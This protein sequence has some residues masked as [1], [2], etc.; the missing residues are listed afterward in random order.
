LLLA[1]VVCPKLCFGIDNGVGLTPPMGWRSWN[2]MHGD[3]SDAR[4][5]ATVD[6]ITSRHR[7]VG[8]VG[9]SLADLGFDRVGIDDGWQ[10]CNRGKNLSGGTFHADDGTPLVN[11]TLFPNLASL[12]AFAKSRGVKMGWYINNCIC[13][14]S[15]G[16]IGGETGKNGAWVN[17]TYIGDVKQV[18]AAGFESVKIDSCGLHSDIEHYAQLFNASGHRVMIE[19]CAQG[20]V[21]GVRN[22]T[23]TWC[24]FNLFRTGGDI[25]P[26]F[27][28]VISKLQRT[29]PY[30]DPTRP[31]SRPGCWGYPDM[32]EVGNFDETNATLDA[33]ESQTHFGAWCVVSSPLILGLDLTDTARVD[34]VWDIISNKE[35]I[36]VNQAWAGH[37][38]RLVQDGGRA[39]WQLW[40]KRLPGGA[41]AAL[42]FNRGLAPVN[43]SISLATLGLPGTCHAR[44]IWKRADI[45]DVS[46]TWDVQELGVHDSRFVR[47]S[48]PGNTLV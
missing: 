41:Q 9:T 24:P 29:I 46:G 48:A 40:A 14:E 25:R 36:A 44:D 38:G 18:T 7:T 17:R 11:K 10:A 45:G 1:A 39:G 13:H 16:R 27:E 8:G 5:R 31:V 30:L 22:A 3:I 42:L 4:I 19:E 21:V 35:A 6:A 28:G 47:F 43:V 12:V 20:G 2:C 33:I 23:E 32:L 34:G 15:K 26:N 37:P